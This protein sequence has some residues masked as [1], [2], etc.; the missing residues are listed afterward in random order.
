M[1]HFFKLAATVGLK[2]L[3][4][5]QITLDGRKCPCD[6]GRIFVW[7]YAE[8][9]NFAVK[10]IDTDTYLMPFIFDFDVC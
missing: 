8:I 5:S 9:N 6:K 1:S 3:D 7:P 10:E 2:Q 4:V